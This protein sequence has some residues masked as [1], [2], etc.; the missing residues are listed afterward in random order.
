MAR[1]PR[2]LLDRAILSRAARDSVLKLDPRRMVRNPVM[3]IVEVGSVAVT[4]LFLKD[5][6]SSSAE[7]NVFAGLVA[8]W[9]GGIV[10]NLL[11]ADPP[12][13]YDVALRDVGLALGALA[14]SRL[15]VAARRRTTR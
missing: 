9:L 6:G 4:V 12:R 8:A 14:L 3:F 7:E 5:L 10:V 1:Q 15:A 11:T 13:F 2:S